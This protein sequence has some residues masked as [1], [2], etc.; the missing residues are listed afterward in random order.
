MGFK[1]F[2]ESE[3]SKAIRN[4]TNHI[5]KKGSGKNSP[6]D[7]GW[8][9]IGDMKIEHI[10]IPNPHKKEF[11]EGKASRTAKSLRLNQKEWDL[12]ISCIMK[13]SEYEDLLLKKFTESE[14]EGSSISNAK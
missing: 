9:M 12:F 1:V 11:R 7:T 5:L 13:K 2:K 10:K 8:L 14:K 6:H 4:K 3:V